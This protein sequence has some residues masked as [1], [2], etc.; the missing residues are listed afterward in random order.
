MRN[1]NAWLEVWTDP[2]MAMVN[3]KRNDVQNAIYHRE[4]E[5]CALYGIEKG[6]VKWQDLYKIATRDV[7]IPNEKSSKEEKEEFNRMIAI[8][9]IYHDVLLP[10]AAGASKG[11]RPV[12]RHNQTI[13][14]AKLDGKF[15]VNTGAEA[16]TVLIVENNQKRWLMAFQKEESDCGRNKDWAFPKS[17]KDP[18]TAQMAPKYSNSNLGATKYGGYT[19]EGRKRYNYLKHQ[20]E[21]GRLKPQTP[22][23][24]K[25]ILDK[26]REK[27][28]LEGPPNP[29]AHLVK[30]RKKS[31]LYDDLEECC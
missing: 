21:L 26:V 25:M 31:N 10:P 20:C 27:H 15:S 30:K 12:I 29:E 13:S 11:F 8:A 14:E 5:M 2:I 28:G 6:F 22:V 23:L 18:K 4:M 9:V 3:Q 1:R 16:M 17:K 7:L 24:E 19:N